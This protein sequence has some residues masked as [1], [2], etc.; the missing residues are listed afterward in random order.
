[1]KCAYTTDDALIVVLRFFIYK[2]DKILPLTYNSKRIYFIEQQVPILEQPVA[3]IID[4]VYLRYSSI[5]LV[6]YNSINECFHMNISK[7]FISDKCRGLTKVAISP[8]VQPIGIN[9][10]ITFAYHELISVTNRTIYRIQSVFK[11]KFTHI[12]QSLLGL[13]LTIYI[14]IYIYIYISYQRIMN[15]EELSSVIVQ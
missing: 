6:I 2:F 5:F 1:M 7:H 4:V 10:F 8:T 11:S 15:G 14:Y 3:F 13:L 9:S 12:F